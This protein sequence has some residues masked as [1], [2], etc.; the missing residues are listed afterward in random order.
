MF[1]Q[2]T[3]IAL[4]GLAFVMSQP[5]GQVIQSRQIG[6]HLGI[7]GTYVAK[8]FQPF[9]RA[10]WLR[11]VKGRAGGWVLEFEPTEHTIMDA[12]DVLEPNDTWKRCVVGN[13]LC[14]EQ[15]DGCPFHDTWRHTVDEFEKLMKQTRLAR[16]PEFLP[17]CYDR[18]LHASSGSVEATDTV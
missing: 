15:R 17:P 3:E 12:V 13:V 14:Q 8:A 4:R 6:E 7:S 11:S 9:A 10:N 1:Q 2:M 5:E 16:L 18:T